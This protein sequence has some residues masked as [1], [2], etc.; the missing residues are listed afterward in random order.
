MIG[1][2]YGPLGHGSFLPVCESLVKNVIQVINK[3]Q[4]DRIKSLYPRQEVVDQ[5]VEHADLFLHRTAWASGCSSWFK[6]G[7][8]DGPLPMFPGSRLTYLDL[9]SAPRFED[10]HIEYLNKMNQFEFI[11]N[12]FDVREFDGRDM[13]YY[14][15]LLKN[16]DK[17]IDLEGTVLQDM[18]SVIPQAV[19]P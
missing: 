7:R 4:K 2:P 17:Q 10:Y 5:F 3:V 9:L 18:A 1:G 13:S 16:E 11:G 12:G 6:Q 8:V 19:N 14:L 15:G